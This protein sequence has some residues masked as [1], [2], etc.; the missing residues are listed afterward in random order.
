LAL[1]LMVEIQMNA[2]EFDKALATADDRRGEVLRAADRLREEEPRRTS[3]RGRRRTIGGGRRW[4]AQMSLAPCLHCAV[5]VEQVG[6]RSSD[7][8]VRSLLVSGRFASWQTA[9]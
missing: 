1:K 4:S 8:T 5:R 3:T 7:G 9:I 2:G 6:A